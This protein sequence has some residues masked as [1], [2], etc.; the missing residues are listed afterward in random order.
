MVLCTT[1]EGDN[2][3]A[4]CMGVEGAV[5]SV[6]PCTGVEGEV[7]TGSCAGVVGGVAR[8]SNAKVEVAIV[9]VSSG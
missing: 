6:S 8:E 1:A 9:V 4:L 7:S 2:E 3:V 5:D